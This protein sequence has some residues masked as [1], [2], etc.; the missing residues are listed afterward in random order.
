[1]LPAALYGSACA[2]A[3]CKPPLT[4][5][6]DVGS[7]ESSIRTAML[8]N[9]ASVAH[10]GVA[11][12]CSCAAAKALQPAALERLLRVALSANGGDAL[13]GYYSHMLVLPLVG[14]PGRGG[15]TNEPCCGLSA[16]KNSNTFK[17]A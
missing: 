4:P 2:A 9:S 11:L 17:F 12:L 1:V 15:A 14:L 8:A 5:L 3:L 7:C 13:K 6:L 10:H 16:A